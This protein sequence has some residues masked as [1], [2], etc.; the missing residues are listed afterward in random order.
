MTPDPYR[1]IR[2]GFFRTVH[3]NW[4]ALAAFLAVATCCVETRAQIFDYPGESPVPLPTTPAED[5][6]FQ[7]GFVQSCCNLGDAFTAD[8]FFEKDGHFYVVITDGFDH[9]PNVRAVIIPPGT[10]REIPIGILKKMTLVDATGHLVAPPNPTH[11]GI[12]F[13]H[14]YF[15]SGTPRGYKTCP[16]GESCSTKPEDADVLCYWPPAEG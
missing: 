16:Q 9:H 5:K 6:W 8:E 13:L 2:W 14:V 4:F 7:T 1:G 12:L 11:H 3:V 15:E 10:I